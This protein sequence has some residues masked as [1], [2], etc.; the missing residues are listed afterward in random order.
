MRKGPVVLTVQQMQET[1][2]EKRVLFSRR[3]KPSKFSAW[4]LKLKAK[5]RRNVQIISAVESARRRLKLASSL[6][7]QRDCLPAHECGIDCMLCCVV[8][9]HGSSPPPTLLT[10]TR[11]LPPT[12]RQ[13][14]L[15]VE[16]LRLGGNTVRF[17]GFRA[18]YS[19]LLLTVP[20]WWQVDAPGIGR[21]CGCTNSVAGRLARH[22][23]SA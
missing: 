15:H 7:V 2:S 5:Q 12:P 16:P 19:V 14:P 4:T 3:S 18:C 11:R 17:F 13:L 1:A 22:R 21:T 6:C 23:C 20:L 9:E 10:G 8:V